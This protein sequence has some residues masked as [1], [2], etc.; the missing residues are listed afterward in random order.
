MAVQ[1]QKTNGP[2]AQVVKAWS[3]V[4]C[5]ACSQLPVVFL[6]AL[7]ALQTAT[8]VMLAVAVD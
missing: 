2:L 7:L 6:L 8:P 1:G 3:V 4:V 5:A